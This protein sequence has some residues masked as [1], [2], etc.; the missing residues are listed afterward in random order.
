MNISRTP[1]DDFFYQVMSRRET[2]M[3][4]FERYLPQKVLA[5][6]NLGTITL[7][8]SK[9]VS[10]EGVSLYNDVL[11]R[12]ELS[13]GQLGYL[14][15]M[16]EH[17]STP[18]SQMPLRLLEYNIGVIRKH[19]KQAQ[20]KFPVIVN[21]VLYHGSKPWNYST[22]FSDY[23]ANPALGK[24]FLDMA[25]FTLINIPTLPEATILR[26]RELGFCFAAFRC[27]SHPDPYES[28]KNTMQGSAFKTYFYTLSKEMRNLVLAYLLNCVDRGKHSIE[29]LV[30]L[31][32]NNPQE[33]TDIMTS[34]AQA[35]RQEGIQEGRQEGRY[36]KGLEIAKNMLYANESKE[37]IHQFT[38]LSRIEIEA[39]IREQEK[40]QNSRP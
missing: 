22:T 14:C 23:Y 39:L 3:A 35:I 4:F 40:L 25:P 2:A 31:V 18:E 10:D 33:K 30:N 24:E 28:F 27:T 21:I 9:H 19:L 7:A 17:Q 16:C 13:E 34:I 8:E 38:G 36:T 20:G 6:I 5:M 26:D 1:H 29:D 37:R 15:A 11:Y 32:S 12:C